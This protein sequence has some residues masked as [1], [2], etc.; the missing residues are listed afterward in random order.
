VGATQAP[1][2]S[3]VR[4]RLHVLSVSNLVPGKGVDVSLRALALARKD[5][6]DV[7]YTVVGD[8]RSRRE[9]ERLAREVGV[10]DRVRFLGRLEP[11]QVHRELARCDLFNLP[12]S[13]EAFGIVY[14]EAM[15]HGKPIVGCIGEGPELFCRDGEDGF[16][17]PPN[18]PAAVARA[19]RRARD[20]ECRRTLGEAARVRAWAE[21]TWDA[22][23]KRLEA[24]LQEVAR[25]L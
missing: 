20:P 23:A 15:A 14:V 3:E 9:L 16:L 7:D 17:V 4:D 19:W 6:L 10:A 25:P 2:R 13:P 1:T 5:G 18:D 21:F 11:A 24:V 22:S 12:S 8:G